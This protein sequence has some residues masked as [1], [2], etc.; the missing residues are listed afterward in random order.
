MSVP[1]SRSQ[2][3]SPLE[4]ATALDFELKFNWELP[5][6]LPSFVDNLKSRFRP[7]TAPPVSFRPG[8]FWTDVFV[9]Q[10]LD[11]KNI[12]RSYTYH[13]IFA[14]LVYLV[15]MPFY[16]ERFVV[17]EN[18]HHDRLSYVDPL[19]Q[20]DVAPPQPQPP[21]VQPVISRSSRAP[22]A[23]ASA[24]RK[25]VA[26]AVVVPKYTDNKA[27]TIV[28]PAPPKI[29]AQAAMPDVVLWT[30]VP[31]A[32][33][34]AAV[35]IEQ[36]KLIAPALEIAPVA[37][38]PDVVQARLKMP[39]L[40]QPA[41]VPPPVETNNE[42]RIADLKLP[43]LQPQAVNAEPKLTLS[44]NRSAAEIPSVQPVAPAPDAHIQSG[45]TALAKVL[46]TVAQPVAPA[47]DVSTVASKTNLA[48]IPGTA[49]PVAPPPDISGAGTTQS[50]SGALISLNVTPLAGP[51]RTPE[52]NRRGEFSGQPN[53]PEHAAGSPER[54]AG[55]NGPGGDS[56][57]P[58]Q[59]ELGIVASAIPHGV[60]NGGGPNNVTTGGGAGSRVS[61]LAAMS[62]PRI[63]LP[64]PH[65][66]ARVAQPNSVDERVFHGRKYYT[67]ALNTPNLTSAG[68]SW[69]FRF[70]ERSAGAK[71]GEVT[72]PVAVREID[73]AY[74][75]DLMRDRIEGVVILYAVIRSD[76]SVAEVK[77][78]EGFD[79][80][81][82]ENARQALSGWQFVPGTRNGNPV[83]LEAV[84]RIP[85]R[86]RRIF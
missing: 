57:V 45:A 5:P 18:F 68:G 31:Q 70:A 76:G 78:L 32:P 54:R 74:P 52:G 55:G 13:L 77:V 12:A 79:D 28:D 75:A 2:Q 24:A 86:A 14:G 66:P 34:V 67:M 80:R 1:G 72:A 19:E 39:A 27:H 44:E 85:F 26:D 81:L 16:W 7:E 36:P 17:V 33:P 46:P 42:R 71:A 25:R 60:L 58:T 50:A 62:A 59:N 73:P 84:V 10:R 4:A 23:T 53:A 63:S 11:P 48:D 38:P 29:L 51:L 30:K 40:P 8:I 20:E 21:S 37:P 83:D 49:Q 43:S 6:W 82:D 41:V 35:A 64:P 9:N 22:K 69:I 3:V 15:S 61:L 56:P 47:P 65:S